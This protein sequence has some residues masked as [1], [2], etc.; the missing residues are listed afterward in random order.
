[1]LNSYSTFHF[2]KNDLKMVA[3]RACYLS[4]GQFCF[5]GNLSISL[6]KYIIEFISKINA[7]ITISPKKLLDM[8][9]LAC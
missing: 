7:I 8:V 6:K 5:L 3:F 1:M 9:R 4:H 2:L